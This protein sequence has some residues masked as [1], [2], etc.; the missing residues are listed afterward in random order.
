MSPLRGLRRERRKTTFLFVLTAKDTVY[1]VL[2]IFS[3]RVKFTFDNCF[4]T[5]K[6]NLSVRLRLW[7]MPGVNRAKDSLLM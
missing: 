2:G 7:G 5:G 6:R 1:T 3:F 4:F